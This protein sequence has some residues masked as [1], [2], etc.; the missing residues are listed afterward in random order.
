[1]RMPSLLIYFKHAKV[2]TQLLLSDHLQRANTADPFKTCLRCEHSCSVQNMLC[3]TA[4]LG[5]CH[6]VPDSCHR[7]GAVHDGCAWGGH[8]LPAAGR[9]VLAL[10]GKLPDAAG[11][12]HA[13]LRD[14]G[15]LDC[16]GN[17]VHI[18][19]NYAKPPV[20][21][22]Y[23]YCMCSWLAFQSVAPLNLMICSAVSHVL[24]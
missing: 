8:P 1:M 23:H 17:V 2:W 19:D 6:S 4:G 15:A 13:D 5:G 21:I 24:D 3:L 20:Q 18:H 14:S 7:C 11:S 16:E 22:L 9:C 10:P 12:A